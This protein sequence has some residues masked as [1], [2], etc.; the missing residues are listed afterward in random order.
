VSQTS[1]IFALGLGL[2]LAVDIG[3]QSSAPRAQQVPQAEEPQKVFGVF[4]RVFDRPEVSALAR[5]QELKALF[6]PLQSC[7]SVAAEFHL[8][9]QILTDTEG[10]ILSAELLAQNPAGKALEQCFRKNIKGLRVKVDG[11]SLRAEI[12]LGV[13]TGPTPPWLLGPDT[14]LLEK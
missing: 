11:S 8:R 10:R 12:R 14:K 5:A 7:A 4:A 9:F 3:C 13:Y 2:S 6:Q 1:I